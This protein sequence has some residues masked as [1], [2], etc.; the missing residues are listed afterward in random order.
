MR[1]YNILDPEL[2]AK[3]AAQQKDVNQIRKQLEA[4]LNEY[5]TVELMAFLAIREH[6]LKTIFYDPA[7]PRSEKPYIVGIINNPT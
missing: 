5:G 2:A 1:E 3:R 6:F 4:K 7:E